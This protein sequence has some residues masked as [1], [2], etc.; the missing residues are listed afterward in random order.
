MEGLY[1]A[2]EA[3]TK[4]GVTKDKFQYMTR[5]RQVKKVIL[6]GRTYGMYSRSEIDELAAEL[7][8]PEQLIVEGPE[9]LV[10]E[11]KDQEQIVFRKARATDV[12]EMDSL[13]ARFM[14]QTG[15]A[16]QVLPPTRTLEEWLMNNPFSEVGHVLLKRREVIGYSIILP[17]KHEQTM[18]IMSREINIEELE[19]R[20]LA[21]L[22]SG[23]PIDLFIVA[24]ITD[25]S[26]KDIGAYL[27]RKMLKFFHTL[28]KQGVEIAGIYAPA[29]S[30]ESKALCLNIGMHE[31]TLPREPQ[32][33][34]PFEMKVKE[35]YNRYTRNYLLALKSYKEKQR[36][37]KSAF[38]EFKHSELKAEAHAGEQRSGAAAPEHER[39]E[40]ALAAF[41]QA[42]QLDPK[43]ADAYLGKGA[44]LKLLGRT[45]KAGHAYKQAERLRRRSEPYETK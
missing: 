42:I 19:S 33:W 40:E 20:D 4:L 41:E 12:S 30:L 5:T 8:G 6:P 2:K 25:P 17:L 34:I 37:A 28:G 43:N 32:S 45:Q 14:S 21:S 26:K 3:R 7:H 31:M 29:Y 39:Y 13:G 36:R 35:T 38:R 44:A 27:I 16:F 11:D 18:Q 9:Q 15:T 1:T 23:E 10:V 24:I 22:E